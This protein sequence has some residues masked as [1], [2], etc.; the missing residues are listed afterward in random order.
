MDLLYNCPEHK[1]YRYLWRRLICCLHH[2][3]L[4]ME[5]HGGD[6]AFKSMSNFDNRSNCLSEAIKVAVSWK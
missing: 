4:I 5:A 1:A 3:V 2:V 6:T